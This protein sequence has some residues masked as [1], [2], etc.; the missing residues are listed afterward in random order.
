MFKSDVVSKFMDYLTSLCYFFA[1]SPKWQQYFDTFID[2]HKDELSISDSN[3]KHVIMLAKT[4]W[5]ER[6]ESYENYCILYRFVVPT[7]ESI[8]SPTLYQKF[9]LELREKHKKNGLRIRKPYQKLKVFLL[10]VE[11]LII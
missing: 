11:G 10:H 2:Y 4:C 6:H 8:C 1:K 7:F 9:Y 3:K 5:V